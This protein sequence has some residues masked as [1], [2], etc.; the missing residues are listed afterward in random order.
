MARI[1]YK[2]SLLTSLRMIGGLPAHLHLVRNDLVEVYKI[3]SGQS[4]ME[5]ASFFQ[6]RVQVSSRTTRAVQDQ[7]LHLPR[8]KLRLRSTS[9]ACRVVPL[10]NW[11]PAHIRSAPSLPLFRYWVTEYL[12]R[13]YSEVPV[14]S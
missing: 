4:C 10:W 9:F 8:S 11:V 12:V 7:Q 6:Y 5:T 2:S 3:T 1:E 14:G 13:H